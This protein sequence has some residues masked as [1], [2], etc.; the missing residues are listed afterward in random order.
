VFTKELK[1]CTWQTIIQK[2]KRTYH[3][4]YETTSPSARGL[5]NREKKEEEEVNLSL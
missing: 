1:F 3:R 5:V 2:R 4:R